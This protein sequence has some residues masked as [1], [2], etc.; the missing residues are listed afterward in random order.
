MHTH[1]N[2]ALTNAVLDGKLKQVTGTGASGSFRI[3]TQGAPK[4]NKEADPIKKAKE[5]AP[6]AAARKGSSSS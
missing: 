2:K 1:I 6:K 3:P 5:G 4:R